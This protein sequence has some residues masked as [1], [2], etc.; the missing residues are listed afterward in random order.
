[1][2]SCLCAALLA[3]G[4]PAVFYFWK[5]PAARLSDSERGL[6]SFSQAPPVLPP[7]SPRISFAGLAC[8]VRVAP[9]SGPGAAHPKAEDFRLGPL[10]AAPAAPVRRAA[11][12]R[13]SFDGRPN[14]SMIYYDSSN[15]AAIIDGQ[16]L[17]EGSAFGKGLIVRIE[18][19]RV[20]MKTD[21]K[22]IWLSI[23]Q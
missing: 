17:H 15:K 3:I 5:L 16:V 1:M 22:D 12:Q 8:P 11:A 13:N 7:K 14:V 23:D 2:R 6:I 9:A 19:T 21:Q 20:L 10:P 4:I 18:K